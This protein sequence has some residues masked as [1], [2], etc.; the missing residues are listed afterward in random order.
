MKSEASEYRETIAIERKIDGDIQ[1]QEAWLNGQVSLS[2]SKYAFE[3]SD[4]F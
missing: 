2:N 1:A 3:D 4:E